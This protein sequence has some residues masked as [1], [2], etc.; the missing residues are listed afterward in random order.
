MCVVFG[1]GV[2]LNF[3]IFDSIVG[4]FIFGINFVMVGVIVCNS[5]VWLYNFGFN[6]LFF[7]NI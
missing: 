7:L 4:N 3:F 5:F 2:R 6:I 1:V